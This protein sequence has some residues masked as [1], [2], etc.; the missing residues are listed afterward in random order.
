MLSKSHF[1]F[2][3]IR[4]KRLNL[5]GGYA[6]KKEKLIK[7][8]LP[9]QF[10]LAG[11]HTGDLSKLSQRERAQGHNRYLGFLRQRF[12]CFR[13]GGQS[14]RDGNDLKPAQAQRG[15]FTGATGSGIR[16]QVEVILRKINSA[17]ILG[18]KGVSM[19]QSSAR[20]EERRVGKECRARWVRER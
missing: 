12:Q 5:C 2:T 19:A 18:N 13:G 14:V 17:P 6:G 16:S 11:R 9:D 10:R 20:S 3:A 4:E 7:V 1:P 8:A 15:A